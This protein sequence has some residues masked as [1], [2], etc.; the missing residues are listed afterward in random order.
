MINHEPKWGFY[1][2]MLELNT[3]LKI[4]HL[5]GLIAGFG[6]A[7]YCDILIFRKGIFKRIDEETLNQLFVM[8]KVV[9]LGLV[10]LW[11]SGVI[12]A[13]QIIAEKPMFWNNDKFWAKVTIVMVLTING[14]FI[15]NWALSQMRQKLG[16]R[17][18]EDTGFAKTA[19]FC[20]VA[21]LSLS[22]WLLPFIMGSAPEL[23][24]VIAYESFFVLYF[25]MIATFWSLL[26]AVGSYSEKYFREHPQHA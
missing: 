21:S 24:Y 14:F 8:S 16:K 20:F 17:L 19:V 6:G 15:H 22:S 23:S 1:N 12:L 2:M 3:L 26:M 7:L 9:L 10:L 18:F 11:V 25:M 4:S 5:V 13:N